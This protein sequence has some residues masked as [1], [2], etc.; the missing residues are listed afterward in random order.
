MQNISQW[1]QKNQ[2]R[3]ELYPFSEDS[4]RYQRYTLHFA[5]DARHTHH[6]HF[7]L[8]IN[9]HYFFSRP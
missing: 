4:Q 9:F 5:V 1:L 3:F 8:K 6:G 2:P 7:L